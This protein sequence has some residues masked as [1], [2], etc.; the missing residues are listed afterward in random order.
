MADGALEVTIGGS[1]APL[2]DVNNLDHFVGASVDNATVGTA[3][4]RAQS[5]A[6]QADNKVDADFVQVDATVSLVGVGVGVDV[7]T[8]NS[9]TVANGREALC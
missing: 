6:V 3:T 8:L 2:V 5:I 9:S 7:T 1:L 4:N